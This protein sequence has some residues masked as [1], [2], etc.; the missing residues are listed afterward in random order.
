VK[1]AALWV[2]IL[3]IAGC[4]APPT[5]PP[6]PA[7][8]L[9]PAADRAVARLRPDSVEPWSFAGSDGSVIRT[10]HYRIFTTSDRAILT[11]R[12]PGFLEAALD[13]YRSSLAPLPGPPVKLDTYLMATR[14]EWAA[15]TRTLMRERAGLYLQIERGG[16]AAG[17]RGVYR[18]LGD[19]N[20][21]FNLAAHEGWHQYTQLTFKSRL[22]IYLEEGIAV[23]MEGF[24]WREDHPDRP[25]FRPWANLERFR[26]LRAAAEAGRLMSLDEVVRSS[27]QTLIAADPDAALVW[28]AQVWALVHFLNEGGGGA[29][30][31]AFTRLLLDAAGGALPDPSRLSLRDASR[32]QSGTPSPRD[33]FERYFGRSASA[34]DGE[35]RAF[36]GR[37]VAPGSQ[38]AI[39]AGRSPL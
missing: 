1:P 7:P 18:D 33:V 21:T 37:V 6:E 39:A 27:P 36:I 16:F 28:Y 35:Y 20:D 29:H 25:R 11:G 9:L 4:S 38:N 2:A 32:G 24:A 13:Q 3:P 12:L 15:L 14:Q 10:A 26:T 34:L 30:K 17:G 8:A 22:P 31:E 23:Y 5:I 19:L